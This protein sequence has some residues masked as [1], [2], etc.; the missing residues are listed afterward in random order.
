[1]WRLVRWERHGLERVGVFHELDGQR[2]I[3]A[4]AVGDGLY[5]AEVRGETLT[6][7]PATSAELAGSDVQR[8]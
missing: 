8:A 3:F 6:L 1:M 2:A 5:S 4:R 7:R